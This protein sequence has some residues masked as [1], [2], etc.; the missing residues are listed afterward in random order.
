[1]SR[2]EKAW[3]LKRATDVLYYEKKNPVKL[4]HCQ[5]SRS[6]RISYLMQLKP[7]KERSFLILEF[8]YITWKPR[9]NWTSVIKLLNQNHEMRRQTNHSNWKNE[10]T[11]SPPDPTPGIYR[12]MHPCIEFKLKISNRKK[13]FPCFFDDLNW[14]AKPSWL[15]PPQ[16]VERVC[17]SV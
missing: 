11:D 1:M 12:V 9:I 2:N 4:K 5:T 7:Q 3:K 14:L 8:D 6:Y 13:Y 10:N 16:S 15:R 17:S